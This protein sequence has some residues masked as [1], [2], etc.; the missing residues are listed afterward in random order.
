MRT[1]L[2]I[3]RQLVLWYERLELRTGRA[4]GG[5]RRAVCG[6]GPFEKL[7]YRMAAR[8]V[9]CCILV[10]RDTAVQDVGRVAMRESSLAERERG[11]DGGEHL[12][13]ERKNGARG[14]QPK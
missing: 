14:R 6:E 12:E 8:V 11:D 5:V 13:R 10:I 3:A 1:K 4:D 2:H 9:P 7:A